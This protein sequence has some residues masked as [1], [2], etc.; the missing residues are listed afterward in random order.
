MRAVFVVTLYWIAIT[1]PHDHWKEPSQRAKAKLGNV[2][3]ITTDEI[4]TEFL[5]ALRAGGANIRRQAA[6]MVRAILN[7]PNV[8]VIPQ[9]RDS[10]VRGLELYENRPDKEYSLT[11]CISMN[12]MRKESVQEILTNDG[13]FTQEGFT[14]LIT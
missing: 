11:D 12:A 1:L 14:I 10:F 3:L 8:K 4:L 9:S 2:R 13:H 7:N 5:T 6:K